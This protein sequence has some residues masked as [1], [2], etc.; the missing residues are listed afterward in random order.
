MSMRRSDRIRELFDE[1]ADLDQRSRVAFLEREEPDAGV[2]DEVM[3]LVGFDEHPAGIL[4]VTVD[5]LAG[6]AGAATPD[7]DSYIGRRVGPYRVEGVLGSGGMGT[8]FLA[9]RDDIGL[10]VAL[11]LVRGALGDPGRLTRFRQEAAVLARLNHPFIAQLVDAGVADDGTPFLA[12]EYVRGSPI[13]VWCDEQRLPVAKLLKLFVELCDAVSFAHQHLVVHRDIKPLNILVTPEGVVKLLDFGVAK[14]L[15][16]ESE[17]I[18]TTAGARLFS[19]EYASPEQVLGAPVSMATDVHGLGVLLYK[20]LTGSRPFGAGMTKQADILSAILRDDP[21]RPSALMKTRPSSV[22]DLDAICFH[23]LAKAPR[24]RYPTVAT[25]AD[26]VRNYLAGLPVGARLPTLRYRTGKFI[27]RHAVSVAIGSLAVALL[28]SAGGVFAWRVNE[29]R[30]ALAQAQQVSSYL[31]DVFKTTDPAETRGTDAPVKSYLDLAQLYMDG[32]SA[33]PE[34][35]ARLLTIL[36]QAYLGLGDYKTADSLAARSLEQWRRLGGHDPEI[37]ASLVAQGN[38]RFELDDQKTAT[39]AFRSA[40]ALQRT[41]LGSER[42]ETTE[43]MLRLAEALVGHGGLEEAESL[44]REALAIRLGSPSRTSEAV[45]DA[46]MR[47]GRV[48]GANGGDDDLEAVRLLRVSLSIRE[49]LYGAN[50]FRVDRSLTPLVVYLNDR[51]FGKEAEELARRALKLRRGVYGEGHPRTVAALNNLAST[52]LAQNRVAEARDMYRQVVRQYEAAFGGD[53]LMLAVAIKNVAN[54]FKRAGQLD[55]AEVHLTRAMQMRA[56]LEG[57][58]DQDV[59]LLRFELGELQ[60]TARAFDRAEASLREA[61]ARLGTALGASNPATL[62][63]GS[64]LG[65]VLLSRGKY[66]EAERMLRV[67]IERQTAVLGDVHADLARSISFL[68]ASLTARGQYK[69]ALPLHAKA[70][71]ASRYTMAAWD[72]GRKEIVAAFMAHYRATGQPALAE[73]VR[74]EEAGVAS[75]AAPAHVTPPPI[76][77]PPSP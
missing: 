48:L 11:K 25:L 22:A 56:R 8:V 55:S 30:V 74:L 4:E 75:V 20:L 65:G 42:F 70:L 54:T 57:A 29:T 62:R 13:N 3:E 18:D 68:A 49:E 72:L 71:Q 19:P 53:H 12:M 9:K 76:R 2:R 69:E 43:T 31:L 37:A 39:D 10:Q 23:A 14:L 6:L 16:D 58:G 1:V 41:A 33:Q 28:L 36:S 21:G 73:R 60:R 77:R 26:D 17:A 24:D 15:G 67:V 5:A 52:I 44:A 50:D 59:A 46:T 47:L 61:Y 51:G 35:Q 63:A 45:A 7:A 38:A 32:L 64:L 34:A 66:E 40:L 27:R